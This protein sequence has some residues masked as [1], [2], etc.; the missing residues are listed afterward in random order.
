MAATLRIVFR[1]PVFGVMTVMVI[2][3]FS[4]VEIIVACELLLNRLRFH[5]IAFFILF[6]VSCWLSHFIRIFINVFLLP[7]LIFKNVFIASIFSGSLAGYGIS[8][9][10]DNN[11]K[12]KKPKLEESDNTRTKP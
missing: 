6:I 10:V 4:Q 11:T 8:R 3:L 7:F 9:A 12:T 5:I 2:Y 1:S